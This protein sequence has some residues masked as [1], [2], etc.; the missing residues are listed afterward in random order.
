MEIGADAT[1]SNSWMV[2]SARVM[3]A[4]WRGT[5]AARHEGQSAPV[6]VECV[7]DMPARSHPSEQQRGSAQAIVRM[8]NATTAAT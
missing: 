4:R 6:W 1:T 2:I 3:G 5:T 8:K 7:A